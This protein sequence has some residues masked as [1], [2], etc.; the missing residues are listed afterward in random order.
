VC[1]SGDARAVAAAKITQ[2]DDGRFSALHHAPVRA[3]GRG[4]ARAMDDDRT[5]SS[6]GKQCARRAVG[7]PVVRSSRRAWRT[8]SWW[9]AYEYGG[10]FLWVVIGQMCGGCG[11]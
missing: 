6:M 9:C 10:C 5:A 2:S 7:R 8:L 3:R 11:G 1:E 4:A